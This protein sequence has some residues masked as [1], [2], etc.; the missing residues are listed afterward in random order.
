MEHV[1]NDRLNRAVRCYIGYGVGSF[2]DENPARL[3]AEFGPELDAQLAAKV[4]SLLEELGRFHPGLES[5]PLL[6]AKSAA[7][8]LKRKYPELDPN[9]IAALEWIYSWWWK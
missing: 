2:P 4:K 6:S 1:D 8:E 7:A 5:T 3:I 9:T